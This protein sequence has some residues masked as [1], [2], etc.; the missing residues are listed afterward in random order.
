[1]RC[2][3]GGVLA[4]CDFCPCVFHLLCL[5]RPPPEQGLFACPGCKEEAAG[6]ALDLRDRALI[7]GSPKSSDSGGPTF[8]KGGTPALRLLLDAANGR[9]GSPGVVELMGRWLEG[10]ASAL[11]CVLQSG[12]VKCP[13]T[14]WREAD[15]GGISAAQLSS[16]ALR[17][18]AITRWF[19]SSSVSWACVGNPAEFPGSGQSTSMGLRFSVACELMLAEMH[20][21]R[22]L[23]AAPVTAGNGAG[24]EAG[25]VVGAQARAG[26]VE[27]SLRVHK[28]DG[29]LSSEAQ[30]DLDIIDAALVQLVAALDVGEGG[31]LD[32]GGGHPGLQGCGLG[33]PGTGPGPG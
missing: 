20:L 8:S 7:S 22:A 2:G 17:M 10:A 23:R 25:A 18:E 9:R 5:D 13:G 19:S 15:L 4:C 1:P 26:G 3:D 24:A 33:P 30:E 11:P 16:A 14:R 28:L 32:L 27:G 29:R 12:G 31:A 6:R 21:D